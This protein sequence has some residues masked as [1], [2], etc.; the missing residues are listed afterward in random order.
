[1]ECT[2]SSGIFEMKSAGEEEKSDLRF[3]KE[4][5]S[6]IVGVPSVK[7]F[8]LKQIFSVYDS[9][10]NT[11]VILPTVVEMGEKT[12]YDAVV[13]ELWEDYHKVRKD[14][15]ERKKVFDKINTLKRQDYIFFGMKDI[16]TG[17]DI[18]LSMEINLE[19]GRKNK[20]GNSFYQAITK[21]EKQLKKF[22]LEIT[23]GS[24]GSW[25]IFPYTDDLTEEQET[26]FKAT[27]EIADEVYELVFNRSDT[28][29]Q[30][31]DI[32]NFGAKFGFDVT[33]VGLLKE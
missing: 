2:V 21:M 13:K 31:S 27:S 29:K 10:N 17:E 8:Y 20:A 18:I 24:R 28:E 4:G 5:D 32:R 25:T 15:V 14:D 33:R 1:V 26:N 30:T 19:E 12:L 9:E 11:P 3:L 23:K 7:E 6:I 16:N 22:P